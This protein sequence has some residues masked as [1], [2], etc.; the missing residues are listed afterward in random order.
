MDCLSNNVRARPT[1]PKVVERLLELHKQG[2]AR[3]EGKEAVRECVVCLNNPRQ[4][5]LRP[6]YHVVYLL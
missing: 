4:T 2:P 6:C 1:C 5:R 3:Q